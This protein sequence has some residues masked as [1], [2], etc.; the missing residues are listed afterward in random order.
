[1]SA[2]GK[3]GGTPGKLLISYPLP[4]GVARRAGVGSCS[5][6][7][8][9]RITRRSSDLR[10]EQFEQ[11]HNHP[12]LGNQRPHHPLDQVGFDLGETGP[13][14][15]AQDFNVGLGLLAQDFNL[16]PDLGDISLDLGDIGLGLLAQDLGILVDGGDIG[17]GSQVGIEQMHLLVGQNLGLLL[18]KAVLGQ[19]LDEP[20][21]V[22][23]NR[24]G[25][26]MR[27]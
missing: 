22:K 3:R 5:G 16:S 19:M 4:G 11:R 27:L 15:L 8:V 21:G 17:L 25:H 23:R 10:L 20:M 24:F 18:G 13:G 2:G 14:L 7:A 9:G 12:T 26:G 6:S 1:M